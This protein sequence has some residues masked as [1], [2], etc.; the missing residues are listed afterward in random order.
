M[1]ETTDLDNDDQTRHKYVFV[2]GLGRSGTSVLG[3]NIARLENCTGFKNTGVLEDEGQFLQQV[4]QSDTSYGGAGTFGFDPRA[5][6]TEASPVVTPENALKLRRSWEPYWDAS[7]TIR[8]EK[9]PGNL[10]RTRFLQAI[11]PNS[12]FIVIRRH[13]VAVSMANNQKWR[14]NF[15]P[16]H[17][18][19]DHWRHCHVI[20]E[21]D[22]KYLKHVYELK[23]EDYIQNRDKYHQEIAAF[24]GTRVPEPPKQDG[25]RYVTQSRNPLG[26]CVPESAME[27][28]TGAHNQKYFN[29]WSDFLNNSRF[30]RY[31]QYI[32]VRYEPMVG[33]YGYSLTQGFGMMEEGL[34]GA[35]QIS[36]AAG[37]LYC[38]MADAYGLL[39]RLPLQVRANIMT[40]LRTRLPQP[41]KIRIKRFLRKAS[42][43]RKQ[44]NLLSS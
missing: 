18:L 20:Y 32:A 8:V 19:F 6:L 44:P 37:A 33:K 34:R 16:L 41:V 1:N 13:P 2:C 5:H 38:L 23:Y 30:K 24:L 10:L 31:H 17:K 27:D 29:R 3:R 26:L 39:I 4:Y 21:Q 15:A 11:F 14:M 9:T 40:Q 25:F 35:K 42:L 12:Y 36:V 22:K 43:S 28:V 7:K